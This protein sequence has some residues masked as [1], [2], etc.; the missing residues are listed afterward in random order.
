MILRAAV[1]VV[2]ILLAP[3]HAGNSDPNVVHAR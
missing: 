2:A 1:A 3:S